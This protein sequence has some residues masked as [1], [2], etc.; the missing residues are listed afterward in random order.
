MGRPH[1]PTRMDISRRPI[2]THVYVDNLGYGCWTHQ[3]Q[4]AGTLYPW[5]HKA[6]AVT[7]ALTYAIHHDKHDCDLTPGQ[8]LRSEELV[9]AYGYAS[10]NAA[11]QSTRRSGA[12]SGTKW[13]ASAI[14]CV[15][16][17][18]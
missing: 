4:G 3:L 12:S 10:R 1:F 17:C 6:M 11:M 13:L 9:W 2:E 7:A 18:G 14:S 15:S 8:N 16:A 5:T